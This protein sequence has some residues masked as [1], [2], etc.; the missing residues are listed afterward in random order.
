MSLDTAVATQGKAAAAYAQLKREI[1]HGILAPGA[2]LPETDL[3]AR[4]GA[5]RTPVREAIRR[6]AAEGLIVLEPRRAPMVSRVSIAG[7]RALFEFRRLIEPAA[8]AAVARSL[9]TDRAG[10]AS[11]FRGLRERLAQLHTS[12]LSA[13]FETQFGELTSEF[14]DLLVA[15]TPN[16]HLARSIRELRPHTRRLRLIAHA[17]TD[18]LH[19][20]L[21][22]HIEMC[23]ALVGGDEQRAA[24]AITLHLVHVEQ[25]IFHRLWDSE[26]GSLSAV[27]LS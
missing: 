2:T 14:D 24:S 26:P 25:A 10:R 23:D 11:A 16:E 8:A 1:E 7:A 5:S 13:A 27:E 19:D 6:L 12:Q 18:R 3:V 15:A 4:T 17:D 9:V 20:S 22:E 21:R